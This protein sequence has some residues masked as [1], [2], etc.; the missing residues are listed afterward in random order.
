[1]ENFN[2]ELV[3]EMVYTYGTK[4]VLFF[5]GIVATFIIAGWVAKLTK[6]SLKRS[7][8]DE[9]LVSF[10]SKLVK[11]TIL[12]LGAVSCLGILGI[13]TA[14]F[15]ALLAG[16]GLAIG[17]AL[18]GT[19]GNFAAGVMLLLFRPFR[20]GQY[21]KVAG[22]EG[23]VV[24][25]D[26][27][28]TA[29]DTPDNRRIVVPNGAVFG[30]QIENV[31]FHQTR[32]VD[33]SVGSD[34]AADIDETRKTL[35]AA[36]KGLEYGLVDPAPAVVLTGLGDSSVNWAVRVWVDA[37]DYWPAKDELTRAVKYALDNAN[38]GIPYPQMDLHLSD[39][40]LGK[41]QH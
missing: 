6:S 40:T 33:V 4:I 13:Q 20:S 27:F 34:Y 24:A 21:V 41:L 12:V 30:S 26:I 9:N 36:A 10:L 7:K 32:R 19:L 18:Q 3:M 35:E 1:M 5:V 37:G 8:L 29:L 16:A 25:V 15:A 22:Q 2:K 31:S 14:S 23:T 17:M 28:N 11:W 39:S 38:I